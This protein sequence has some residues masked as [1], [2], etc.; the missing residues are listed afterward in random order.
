MDFYLSQLEETYDDISLEKNR[1]KKETNHVILACLEDSL[2]IT[3][4]DLDNLQKKSDR[5]KDL[6]NIISLNGEMEVCQKKLKQMKSTKDVCEKIIQE[7]LEYENHIERQKIRIQEKIRVGKQY[8]DD[9]NQLRKSTVG[10]SYSYRYRI[11]HMIPGFVESL[12]KSSC[13]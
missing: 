12:L 9:I 8:K 13:L 1:E 11:S 10:C 2:C 5:S 7:C 4:K 3:K 6:F